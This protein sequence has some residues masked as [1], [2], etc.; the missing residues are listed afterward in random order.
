MHRSAWRWLLSTL[1]G[2]GLILTIVSVAGAQDKTL[3][4]RRW[5]AD[6]QINSDGTFDVE[7]TY[8]IQFIGGDFTFGYR[9]ILFD[10]F[11]RL[12]NFGV[13]EGDIR[14]TESYSEE[15]N[16]FYVTQSGDEYV[17][18]WFYPPTRDATRT[19]TIEYTVVGGLIIDE[20]VGD[21]FFWKA[22]GADHA[23]PIASSTVTVRLPP[24]ATVDP[25][26]EPAYFG[27]DATYQISSDRTV[28]TFQAQNIPA[29]QYFEVGVR[30]PSGY[31]PSVEPS[32]QAE[33]ER[34]QRWNDTYRPILNLAT[35]GLGALLLVGGLA[36]VYLMWTARGRDPRTGT[37]PSYLS[38][39]PSNLPPGL[40]GTLVDEKADMQDIIATLVDLARRG[41][42][43]M[44]E[45]ENKI[46][47][48]TTSKDFVFRLRDDFDEPL[49]GY[50]KLLIREMFGSRR[51]VELDDLRNKFYTAI[52]KL[53]R[54]IY[55]EAV[56]QGLFPK[57]PQAVRGRW[58]G[59]GIGG[60]VLS[61]GLG[62]CV[63]AALA[64]QVDAI[65]CPFLSLGLVSVAVIIVGRAMPAKTRKGA[66]E[67]AKWQAFK[68]YLQKAEEFV[69]LK[70]VTDQFDRY[71]PYAV[72][73]GLDRTWVNQ[74]S[75]IES[76]PVPPWY[77]PV[78]VPYDSSH[79]RMRT[80]GVPGSGGRPGSP[81]EGPGPRD[82]R[83]EAVRPGPSLDR[84]SESMFG[85]LSGMSAGLFSMLNST[86]SVL[87]SVPHSSGSGSGG[88]FS[89]G[90]FSGGGGG[91]GGGA[92]F[93]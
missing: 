88:G 21:R 48:L 86:A 25:T 34:E 36:G 84:M 70:E 46:F 33:Y 60:L 1:I 85:S 40:A 74:F 52:P 39:P 3:N 92:G 64:D 16:T 38:E 68:T 47:G 89:G 12:E 15:P 67:A 31:V 56:S 90:G 24:G 77:F 69:D 17:I 4:W 45:K 76:T 73:F 83:G 66:E 8:E 42:I 50:E 82:L 23:Y 19:F 75:R 49:C 18:N 32:W 9:N 29:N 37:V 58:M 20:S 59:L 80:L 65:L 61:L 78:G 27:V 71:L 62:F 6:I 5:D 14:Y 13:R 44:Q 87:S 91:G 79:R 30:F 35:G 43:D 63:A 2:L 10:Q 11:E 7:E 53:Q 41:A 57:S 22:V 93:G 51:E 55:D 28:V 54:E 26:L 81:L 72:A